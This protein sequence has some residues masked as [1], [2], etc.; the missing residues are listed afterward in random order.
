MKPLN[1]EI[2]IEY[3]VPTE[4]KTEGGLYVPPSQDGKAN[5]F[6]R[7]GKVLAVNKDEEEIK[8]GD[9]VLFNY[10]AK[11]FIPKEKNKMLVRREDIYLIV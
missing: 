7:E 6:L 11:V 8:E 4:A 3:E 2:L 10:N 1:N 9:V 5:S